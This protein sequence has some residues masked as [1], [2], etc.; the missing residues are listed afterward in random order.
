MTFSSDTRQYS[1][2]SQLVTA[3][4][5]R[6][7]SSSVPPIPQAPP[8]GDNYIN[9]HDDADDALLTE[10]KTQKGHCNTEWNRTLLFLLETFLKTYSSVL[11]L[12]WRESSGP[13]FRFQCKWKPS[14]FWNRKVLIYWATENCISLFTGFP[15]MGAKKIKCFCGRSRGFRYGPHTWKCIAFIIVTQA[16]TFHHYFIFTPLISV[17]MPLLLF[18]LCL[19]LRCWQKNL[20][21][22]LLSSQ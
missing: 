14:I 10:F 17:Y 20:L 22:P 11:L 19:S 8:S 2:N 21:L 15:N 7:P 4:G 1:L 9:S 18:E 12:P 3:S 16:N 6:I 13:K 5:A